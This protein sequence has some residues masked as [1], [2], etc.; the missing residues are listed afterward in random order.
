MT[1]ARKLVASLL[2]FAATWPSGAIGSPTVILEY[3]ALLD[4]VCSKGR[5]PEVTERAA[6]E[7]RQGTQR[8]QD[9]WSTDGQPLLDAALNEIGIEA[10]FK[11]IRASLISC[12]LPSMSAP[13]LINVRHFISATDG[14]FSTDGNGINNLILHELLHRVVVAALER[15]PQGETPMW[16][17]YKA[18]PPIVRNHI[19]VYAL[20]KIAYESAG[21][22]RELRK[23]KE[24]E[25][26]F[27]SWKTKE[28]AFK[29]VGSEGAA[30]L[31]ED[32]R[33][34]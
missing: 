2:I 27:P 3:G 33:V 28:A 12:G 24:W 4:Q 22:S 21:K 15:H 30:R 18:H 5:P 20:E 16:S 11:E 25:A 14:S 19:H 29:I 7:I 9:R 17:K 34:K 10:P 6:R 26:S 1:H 32:L 23:I 31:V 13:L 8:F